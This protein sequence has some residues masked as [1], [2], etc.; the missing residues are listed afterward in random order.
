MDDFSW[1]LKCSEA[2]PVTEP[3][4][5]RVWS[6]VVGFYWGGFAFASPIFLDLYQDNM[7]K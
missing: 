2:S 5:S 6:W 3:K 7:P 4:A 1:V